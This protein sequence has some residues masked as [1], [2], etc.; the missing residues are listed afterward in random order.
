MP[1]RTYMSELKMYQSNEVPD[2]SITRN[3]H[4]LGKN[5]SF[6]LSCHLSKL[7]NHTLNPKKKQKK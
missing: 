4:M 1:R 7:C 2:K 3:K 6:I 5:Y